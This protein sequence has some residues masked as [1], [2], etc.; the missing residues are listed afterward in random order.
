MYSPQLLLVSTFLLYFS[1]ALFSTNAEDLRPTRS[2]SSL[3]NE[4]IAELKGKLKEDG[5][6]RFGKRSLNRFQ[7]VPL[8]WIEEYYR[9]QQQI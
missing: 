4:L 6:M 1:L 3:Y 5:R 7:F 2:E 8:K 9:R